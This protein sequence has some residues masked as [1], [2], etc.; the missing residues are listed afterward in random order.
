MV[1]IDD[2]TLADLEVLDTRHGSGGLLGLIDRTETAM[3][4]R[5]LLRRLTSPF[6][7]AGRIRDVQ[8]ALRSLARYPDALRLDDADVERARAYLASNIQVVEGP[9][10]RRATT[11]AWVR[12]R[13]ADQVRELR[14][15]QQVLGHVLEAARRAAAG[16]STESEELGRTLGRIEDVATRAQAALAGAGV[17]EADRQLRREMADDL[18]ELFDRLADLDALRS[19]ARVCGTAG[20][21]TPQ[22]VDDAAFLL[23]AEGAF[24]PFVDDAVPNPVRLDG[25]EPLV[26]LTGPNMAGK[27]TYL[28]TVGLLVLLAQVGMDVPAARMRLAPVEAILTSLNPVDNLRAGVSYFMAEVLRVRDAATLV[29]GG[30]RSLVLF[31]EVFKGTNVRDALDASSQ[32]ILGFASARLAG[33]IFSSHLSE[34]AHTFEAHPAIRLHRFDG[35]VVD[36]APR[37]PFTLEPGVSDTRMGLL[38]LEQARVPEL[39]QAIGA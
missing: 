33:S 17:L 26:F 37:F 4:H 18:S 21:T 29:A 39:L 31:D 36:G 13:Y 6:A 34:L 5:A 35:E 25:G 22:I 24:H 16:V 11:S 9:A 8:R 7:D 23:D 30:K 28:R 32:V 20:W 10:L 19:M 1:H 2:V 3:G 12:V 38:L 14:E 15:G 27:T